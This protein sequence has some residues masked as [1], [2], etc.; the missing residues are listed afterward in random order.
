MC[1]TPFPV[2]NFTG[3]YGTYTLGPKAIRTMEYAN[4]TKATIQ[5][6]TCPQRVNPH[7]P[8]SESLIKMSLP[9]F[10]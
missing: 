8:K 7:T 6:D 3:K 5:I 4:H 9:F 1:H 10:P 2:I